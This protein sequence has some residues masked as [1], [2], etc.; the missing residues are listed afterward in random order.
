MT[1]WHGSATHDGWSTIRHTVVGVL[2]PGTYTLA[3][4]LR[5]SKTVF[6]GFGSVPKG[7]W[8][9]VSNCSFTVVP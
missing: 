1:E 3:V 7:S 8:G 6:D 4:D 2:A 9:L 5:I